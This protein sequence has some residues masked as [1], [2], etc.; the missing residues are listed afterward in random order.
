MSESG[1]EGGGKLRNDSDIFITLIFP[2]SKQINFVPYE[3]NIIIRRR[4]P[5]GLR[6]FIF[7]YN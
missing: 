5:L 6:V 3:F 1:M 2:F 7:Y 4:R